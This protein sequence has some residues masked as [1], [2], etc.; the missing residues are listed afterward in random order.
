MLIARIDYNVEILIDKSL[1]D[2]R[3]CGRG[4][5]PGPHS[6]LSAQCFFFIF[7]QF[8]GRLAK[9]IDWRISTLE[10]ALSPLENPGS[11]T[12]SV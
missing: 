2:L 5:V 3:G 6:P 11:A 9:I 12:I 8:W 7:M 10:L 4:G 1:S